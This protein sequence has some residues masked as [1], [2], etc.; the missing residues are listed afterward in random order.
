M[1]TLTQAPTTITITLEIERRNARPADLVKYL[2]RELRK[3]MEHAQYGTPA[4]SKLLNL[5]V[6]VAGPEPTYDAS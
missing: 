6:Q 2:E 5:A 4:G 3:A 1:P